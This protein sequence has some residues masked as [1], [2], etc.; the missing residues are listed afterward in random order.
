MGII[1]GGFHR[2]AASI[3]NIISIFNTSSHENR[4][5]R[6]RQPQLSQLRPHENRRLPQIQR[7]SRRMGHPKHLRMSLRPYLRLENIHIL[8]RLLWTLRMR[9][10]TGRHRLQHKKPPPGPNRRLHSHGLLDIPSI[11]ILDTVLFPW[12]HTHCPFCLV[13]DKEGEIHAVEPV[14]LNPYGQWIEVLDNNFFA[15]PEWLSAVQYLIN[16][17]QPINLHGV[18][19]RIMN[20]EQA[21]WLN[22]LRL[23]RSIHIAW[24]LPQIDLTEKLREVTRYIKPYKL[25]CYILVGFN[26]TIEQDMYRIERCRELGIK[27]Y[28]MPYRDFENKTQPSQYARDLAQYV[29][30]PQIFKTCS[31]DEFSPRKGFKCAEYLKK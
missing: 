3:R 16:T 6:R 19:V 4:I 25:M 18:D 31:F 10:N 26:S 23:R 7:R 20:E 22:K 28:V 24:D 8:A 11:S 9:N 30:K 2:S 15:N 13:H 29:N 21:F 17:N 12:V 27:P 5:N 1:R 14:Q